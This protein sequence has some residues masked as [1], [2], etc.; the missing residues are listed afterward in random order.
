MRGKVGFVLGAAVGYVLGTRAG[1]ARYEQ[2][3]RGAIAVWET[4]LVQQGV[5]AVKGSVN[6]QVQSVKAA[7]SRA[8]KSAFVAATQPQR[9]ADSTQ[10]STPRAVDAQGETSA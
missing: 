7:A 10:P 8:A 5:T 1:R 6:D 3:K 2:I 9:D 4:P